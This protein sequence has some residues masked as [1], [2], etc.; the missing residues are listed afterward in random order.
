MKTTLRTTLIALLLVWAAPAPAYLG[1]LEEVREIELE[2]TQLPR[3]ANGRFVVRECAGCKLQIWRVDADTTYH[4]GINSVPITL[5]EMRS[6]ADSGKYEL[7]YVFIDPDTDV[8]T[9]IALSVPR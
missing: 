1:I 8:V 2:Q 6:A 5:G 9:K 4:V 3:S 7:L